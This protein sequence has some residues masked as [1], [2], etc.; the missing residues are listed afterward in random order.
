MMYPQLCKM[1]AEQQDVT[2]VKLNCNKYNKELG[3][4]LGAARY[5][6]HSS[7]F[8]LLNSSSVRCQCQCTRCRC[9]RL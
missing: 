1:A 7:L 3:K 6:S 2:F 8:C 5:C 9:G 4:T